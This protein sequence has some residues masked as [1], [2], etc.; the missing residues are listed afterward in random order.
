MK[1]LPSDSVA[2]GA[3]N[4]H[5]AIC[6]IREACTYLKKEG[7]MQGS[8]GN[9]TFVTA[10]QVIAYLRPEMNRHGVSMY[11]SK[12][13]MLSR[14][15]YSRG[16]GKAP[17]Q[18]VRLAVTYTLCHAGNTFCEVGVVGEGADI[19]DKS[20][21]KAMTAAL[22]VALR[23]AF[24]L[25]CGDSDPD[26]TESK[27]LFSPGKGEPPAKFDAAIKAIDAALD[28]PRVRTLMDA[29]KQRDWDADQWDLLCSA[30]NIKLDSFDA[31]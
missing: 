14:E 15:T 5:D 10:D 1:V 6:K 16:D 26:H 28:E 23:Q 2:M 12:V 27:P 22:K 25:E 4:I 30:A 21:N 7:R 24:L 19:G 9:Y 8:G 18:L 31:F 29:A 11:P 17:M 20:C 13:E 3:A